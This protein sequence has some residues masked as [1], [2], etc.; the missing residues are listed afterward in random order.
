VDA[1]TPRN[2]RDRANVLLALIVSQTATEGSSAGD[3]KA[4]DNKTDDAGT[5]AN[6]ATTN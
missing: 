5:K 1:G 6:E 4:D 2:M 3:K